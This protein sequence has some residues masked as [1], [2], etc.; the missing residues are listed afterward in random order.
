MGRD[1]RLLRRGHRRLTP[2]FADVD[3]GIDDALALV[4]L[5]ASSDADL[6]GLAATAGNVSVDQ[7]CRNNLGLLRVCGR[8]GV[9]VSR[10]ADQPLATPLRTA[11]DTHGPTGLG[12]AQLLAPA[13]QGPTEYDAAEAWGRAARARPGVLVGVA[14]G[15]LTNLALA[16]R[17]EPALPSLLGRLVVV[18]GRNTVVDPEAAAE[19]YAAWG[20]AAQAN[21]IGVDKLP[22]L[23]GPDVTERAVVTPEFLRRLADAAGSAANPLWDVLEN[24][25]RFRFEVN[26]ERGVGNLAYLHDPVA[27]AVALDPG[28]IETRLAAVDVSPTGSAEPG[29]TTLSWDHRTPNAQVAVDVDAATFLERFLER[30]GRFARRTGHS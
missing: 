21:V 14:T 7:V 16:L 29:R 28:L 12:Y 6:I 5:L 4:F 11:E 27:V 15:P 1:H 24:S 26:V 3:T 2:V 18:G 22:L 19:V 13:E 30:V 10:G 25:V 8:S 9:P 17:A 23:C 20:R